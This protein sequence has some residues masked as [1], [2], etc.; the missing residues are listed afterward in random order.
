MQIPE[1]PLG[2]MEPPR[3][4]TCAE[5]VEEQMPFALAEAFK[6]QYLPPSA[7]VSCKIAMMCYVRVT[8]I[9]TAASLSG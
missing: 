2:E 4:V 9:M 8:Y 1:F 3:Y 5:A 6:E 7:R